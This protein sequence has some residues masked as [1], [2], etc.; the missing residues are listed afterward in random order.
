MA[1]HF[2]QNERLSDIDMNNVSEDFRRSTISLVV[3]EMLHALFFSDSLYDTY[4]NPAT[5]SPYGKEGALT[6]D[7]L[8]RKALKLPNALAKAREHYGCPSMSS[9][10]LE[11]GGMSF[12]QPEPYMPHVYFIS[13]P[14]TIEWKSARFAMRNPA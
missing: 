11:D 4:M 10:P 5:E 12:T 3:H 9:V 14:S 1:S 7:A 13:F 2:L 6:T 8:Y